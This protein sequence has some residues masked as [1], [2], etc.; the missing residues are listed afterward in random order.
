MNEVK[1]SEV[2][3]LTDE[4]SAQKVTAPAPHKKVNAVNAIPRSFRMMR[5]IAQ[6]EYKV[7]PVAT[8]IAVLIGIAYIVLPADMIPDML[9]FLG[10]VDDASIL[11]LCLT[12][13]QRDITAY[14]IWKNSPDSTEH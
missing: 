12:L 9:P 11:A 5:S 2:I 13:A 1:E 14:E 10:Y 6:G 3:D 7:I 4:A 8:I